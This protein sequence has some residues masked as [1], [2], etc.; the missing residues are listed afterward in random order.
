MMRV[1]V[2]IAALV[3]L[4]VVCA[5]CG[6]PVKFT[7]V[8]A[9]RLCNDTIPFLVKGGTAYDLYDNPSRAIS[10]AQQGHLNTLEAV[11]FDT[12]HALSDTESDAT[13]KRLDTFIAA[14]SNA[15]L[16]IV[17]NL[18]EYGQSLQA[19]GVTMADAAWDQHWAQYL[20]FI[21]GRTN[22][23]SH[24]Q[25]ANDATIA[26]VELWGEIPAPNH[27][28]PSNCPVGTG[29]QMQDW[30]SGAFSW[31]KAIAPKIP[32]SSGGFS[33][34]NEAYA[35]GIPWQAI[36]S[37]PDNAT[38]DLAINST[39]DRD[40]TVPM[41]TNYCRGIGKPWFLSAWSS[42]NAASQGVWDI[43]DWLNDDQMALHTAQMYQIADGD[44]PATYAAVGSDFWNLGTTTSNTCDLG[45]QF[46]NT[47]SVVQKPPA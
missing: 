43:D 13:W 11:E 44:P 26:M 30:Y 28:C 40:V 6:P 39:G 41:V 20:T 36:M 35:A 16:H 42:C 46:P 19:A 38:C 21:A 17:L 5:S 34:L 27:S 2:G 33:Y 10:L 7:T 12:Q 47:W 14:A 9:T 37:E 15:G 23:V 29:Q 3:A 1:L 22:T 8:C 45:P 25:Y 31:W 18:S 4:L 24:K 32:I